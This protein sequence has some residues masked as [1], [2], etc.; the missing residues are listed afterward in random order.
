LIEI[1]T[2]RLGRSDKL[3]PFSQV[4]FFVRV[5]PPPPI[6][7][8]AINIRVLEELCFVWLWCQ[9]LQLGILWIFAVKYIFVSIVKAQAV[10]GH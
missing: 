2:V 6:Y 7:N 3:N 1:N 4:G 9:Y 10:N 5:F 8:L